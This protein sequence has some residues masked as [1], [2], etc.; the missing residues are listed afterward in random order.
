MRHWHDSHFH[1]T[2]W[3]DSHW[4]GVEAGAAPWFVEALQI[5]SPIEAIQVASSVEELEA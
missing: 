5:G 4:I 3:H 2:H 1:D